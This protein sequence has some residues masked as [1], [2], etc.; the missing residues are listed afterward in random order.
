[1]RKVLM[2]VAFAA[3]CWGLIPGKSSGKRVTLIDPPYV[4]IDPVNSAIV[5][6]TK[7]MEPM[8]FWESRD[9]TNCNTHGVECWVYDQTLSD[10]VKID[11]YN[12]NTKKGAIYTYTGDQVQKSP[13]GYYFRHFIQKDT[14]WGQAILNKTA[15]CEVWMEFRSN[16]LGQFYDDY[17]TRTI[18]LWQPG[19]DCDQPADRTKP[20]ALEARELFLSFNPL[21]NLRRRLPDNR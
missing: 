2:L 20:P 16:Y 13:L 12:G 5:E 21:W 1:M 14:T 17:D 7:Y 11:Y 6:T 4:V 3:A 18:W 15:G 10:W 19:G 9:T 8:I